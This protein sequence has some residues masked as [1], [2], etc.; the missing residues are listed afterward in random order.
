MAVNKNFVVKNGLEVG[1]NLIQA[2]AATSKVGIGTSTPNYLLHVFGGIG[3]TNIYVSGV[4]TATSYVGSGASLTGLT[5]A[6]AATYGSATQVPQIVVDSNNRITSISNITITG[7]GGGGAST[8]NT[9]SGLYVSGFATFTDGPTVI[10]GSGNSTGTVGQVLQ[11]SGISSGAFIGGN[12]GIGSTNPTSKLHVVGN[13][14]FEGTGVV[15]ATSFRGSA[16]VGVQT[17]SGSSRTYIGLT[18]TISFV[19]S[20]ITI[21]HVTG[22]SGITTFTFTG[23]AGGGGGGS[24]GVTQIVAGSSGN[25]IV[26]PA[27][28]VGIVTLDVPSVA[29]AVGILSGGV[30][31]GVAK[32]ITELNFVG[33]GVTIVQTGA[34]T[35]VNVSIRSSGGA[36][37]TV[38]VRVGTAVTFA[39]VGA[40]FTVNLRTGAAGTV[41]VN[42]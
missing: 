17:E 25:L 23:G 29:G 2:N 5:G 41:S 8:T 21:T 22:T 27:S 34:G 10:I 4:V 28:G 37:I 20:G 11:I 6:T 16:Q 35:S 36:S 7:G 31:I 38:G 40:G 26:T 13:A 32:T 30:R 18:S 39:L 12:L 1:Q 19:G 15:T 9:F 24:G 14:L 42:T 33:S 3:A